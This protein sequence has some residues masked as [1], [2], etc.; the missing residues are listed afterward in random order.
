MNCFML[1]FINNAY[2]EQF[3]I[4]DCGVFQLVLDR[5]Y[6]PFEIHSNPVTQDRKLRILKKSSQMV[7]MVAVNIIVNLMAS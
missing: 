5:P 7:I 1:K 2:G 6:F 3:P 4:T